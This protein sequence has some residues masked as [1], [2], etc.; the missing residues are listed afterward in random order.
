MT[1]QEKMTIIDLI[2]GA[3]KEGG[4]QS[5]TSLPNRLSAGGIP[6][7]V[8]TPLK[9]NLES[10]AEFSIF[11]IIG[12]ETIDFAST[13]LSRF[14][15]LLTDKVPYQVPVTPVSAAAV[16]EAAREAGLNRELY[17]S[18]E[19]VQ[20]LLRIYPA[21]QLM[22]APAPSIS[23][24]ELDYIH[25]IT[26]VNWKQVLNKL[27]RNSPAAAG[28]I[29]QLRG[30]LVH[31]FAAALL[32]GEGM[33]LDDMDGE[34]PRVVFTTGY[35][36]EK[37]ENLYCVLQ[38]N[39]KDSSRQAWMVAG[40]VYPNEQDESGLGAWLARSFFSQP[41]AN[42]QA[43]RT[44][45]ETL[46]A[47]RNKLLPALPAFLAS[48][49][50]GTCPQPVSEDILQYET[51]WQSL[52]NGLRQIPSLTVSE[53][54]PL[55]DI[56]ALLNE[57]D[58]LSNLSRDAVI[59]FE[60]IC[61]G[62]AKL[63]SLLQGTVP[64][65]DLQTVRGLFASQDVQADVQTFREVLRPYVC[66]K[67][68][69]CAA[70]R[71]AVTGSIT[72]IA[73]HFT[74]NKMD[75][76]E[77]LVG[78]YSVKYAFLNSLTEIENILESCLRSAA[79]EETAARQPMDADILE[80][81][82]FSGDGSLSQRWILEYQAL[83]P[84]DPQLRS[85]I[86]PATG[87]DR[88]ELTPGSVAA[89]LLAKSGNQDRLAERYLLLGL[90]TDRNA[91][92]PQLL[93]L[94]RENQDE[95]RFLRLWQSDFRDS[96][97]A[98]EDACYWLSIHC[99]EDPIRWDEVEQFST[100]YPN[101]KQSQAYKDAMLEQLSQSGQHS[102]AYLRWVGMKAPRLNA[103]ETAVAGS[104]MD[105]LY[106]LLADAAQM[107]E[108]GY[109]P[110]EIT[111]I[112]QATVGE[113][114]VGT[115]PYAKALRLYQVQDNKNGSAERLLWTAPLTP[116]VLK[117]LFDI[118]HSAGDYRSLCWMTQKFS[119][120][121]DTLARSAAYAE[122]L[123]QTKQYHALSELMS[124]HPELWHRS[125]LLA[126][127][128]DSPWQE[129]CQREN[130]RPVRQPSE[131]C[132]ALI[133][134][135]TAAMDTLL[136]QEDRMVLWGYTPE[137]IQT[138]RDK[139][140]EG[141]APAGTDRVSVVK[142]F[143]HYQGNHNRDL[144]AYLY[145]QFDAQGDWAVQHL[146]ALAFAEGRYQ[147]ASAYYDARPLLAR[148]P[149]NVSMHMWCLLHQGKTEALLQEA[150]LHPDSLR[151]DDALTQAVLDIARQENMVEFS[152]NLQRTIA[153]LPRNAF[154][155][156]VMSAKYTD[157]QKYVSD[158]DL[159]TSLGYSAESIARF[160]DRVTKPLPAGADG[161][162]LAI[163]MRL[164]FGNDRAI[165]FLL[166]SLDD[167][168]SVRLLMDIYSSAQ[169]WD[170][171]CSLYRAQLPTGIWNAFYEQRYYDALSR[172]HDR[173]NCQLY[174]YYLHS[175][176]NPDQTSAEYH[177]KYLR[178]L[179]GTNQEN[180]A[181]SQ[182]RF[183][184]EGGIE[185]IYDVAFDAFDMVW[186][187]G[188]DHLRRQTALFAARMYLK[189]MDSMPL[190]K[191]KA[192][193][194]LN[195]NLLQEEASEDWIAL[196][197][198]NGLER[199][200]TFLM[201]YFK[202]GIRDDEAGIQSA[203]DALFSM[204]SDSDEHCQ[205]SMLTAVTSFAL[206]NELLPDDA[207]ER[208]ESLLSCWLDV[209]LSREEKT[210]LLGLETVTDT[211]FSAF[212]SFW[213]T[214]TLSQAQIDRILGSCFR[215]DLE[216]N[217]HSSKFFL[218]ATTLLS[219]L[220]QNPS[221]AKQFGDQL[222]LRFSRWLATIP[223]EDAAAIKTAVHYLENAALDYDQAK[224]LLQSQADSSILY[225]PAVQ[226][227]FFTGNWPDL[228][229]SYLQSLFFQSEEE[230]QQ[231][232]ILRQ[233]QTLLQGQ[234]FEIPTDPD[235]LRFAY[236]IVCADPTTENLN[237]LLS[238]YTRAEKE[239]HA[240]IIARMA[241]ANQGNTDSLY[242]WFCQILD[243]QSVDWI[244]YYSQWWAPLF[245]LRDSD[246]QT[247]S[248]ISYLSDDTA[249]MQYR[250]SILRLLISDLNNPVYIGCYL[251]LEKEL[252]PAAIAK[253]S[254]IRATHD[255][256]ACADA[257]R[258]CIANGQYLY[259]V[260]LLTT[261]VKPVAANAVFIGQT[262]SEIYT[263]EA[264]AACPELAEYVPDVFRLIIALNQAD[265]V[266]AW[267]NIGRAVDIAILTRQETVFLDIFNQEYQNMYATYSGKCAALIAN[268]ILRREFETA[269]RYIQ[270]CSQRTSDD[271]YL[272]IALLSFVIDEC[273]QT[274]TLSDENEILVRSVPVSGNMRSLEHYGSL[275]HYAL[276]EQKIEACAKAFY[277][278]LGYV[279]QDKAL[280]ACCIQLYTVIAEQLSI[281][282]LYHAA[283]SYLA[284]VQDSLINRTGRIMA[285]IAACSEGE[286][287][288]RQLLDDCR[289]RILDAAVLTEVK[290]LYQECI[291][292]LEGALGQTEMKQFLL[293]AATG[294]WKIDGSTVT[295]FSTF[296]SICEK[297]TALHPSAFYSACIAGALRNHQDSPLSSAIIGL[298]QDYKWG[299]EQLTEA[300]K[301][302]VELQEKIIRMTDSPVELP[303]IFS[304]YLQQVLAEPDDEVFRRL[305]NI[306][307]AAQRNFTYVQYET[308]MF[309]LKEMSEL[310]PH[311]RQYEL[312]RLI[313]KK[314]VMANNIL[315]LPRQ[316]V[317]AGEY[318]MA[319]I[320]AEK[321]LEKRNTLFY[322]TL[323][324]TYLELGKF[325][326]QTSTARKYTLQQLM[327]M[328]TLLSQSNSYVD[329]HKL[330][331]VCPAKWK[332]CLRSAQEFIQGNP[333]NVLYLLN[334]AAFQTHDG[335]YKFVYTLA[336]NYLDNPDWRRSLQE[337]NS[338]LN[339]LPNWG[340]FNL[341][342]APVP[343]SP[344]SVFLIRSTSRNHANLESYKGFVD[345]CVAEMKREDA[346][347]K[348]ASA[349]AVTGQET[350]ALT[351]PDVPMDPGVDIWKLD[352]IADCL[353]RYQPENEPAPEA[354][355][356]EQNAADIANSREEKKAALLKALKLSRSDAETIEI[357]TKLLALMRQ[358]PVTF[359]TKEIC[360]RL[361][362][363][364]YCEKR[365]HT[366]LAVRVTEEARNILYSVVPCFDGFPTASIFSNSLKVYVRECLESYQNLSQF[367][368]DC[369]GNALFSLC[370]VIGRGDR[371]AAAHL[372]KHVQFAREIGTR[373]RQPMTNTERLEWLQ[374]CITSCRGSME[375]PIA[376][377]AKEALVNM[378][379]QEIRVFRNK[380]QIHL[381]VYN[382]QSVVGNECLF[383][384]VENLGSERVSKL[385]I[386]LTVDG[387][388]RSQHSLPA[389][390]GYEMV[391]FAL[392][393]DGDWSSDTLSYKISLKYLMQDGTEETATPVEGIL[394]RTEPSEKRHRFQRYDAS[395]PADS[396]NYIERTSISTTL[397]ANYLVDG[398]FRRFPNFAIYGMKRSGKS[399]VLRRIG[400]LFKEHYEDSLRYVIVSC[401]GITGDIYAR[402]HSVFV[403][404]VLDELDYKFD[405]QNRDGWQE[406]KKKWEDFPESTTD[407]R[408]IDSFY[409][410]LTRQW[411]NDTGLVIL[412]DEIERLYFEVDEYDG[413]TAEGEDAS[414]P[415]D[416]GSNNVE[417]VL[418]NVIN[419]I[420]QRDGSMIRFVL[421]GSDFFTSKIIAEG[422][423]LTQFFQKGVKLNV[424]RMEY[425]EIKAALCAN[426]SLTLHEDT[427]NYLWDIA[428]GLP[429]HSK[430]FCNSVIENQLIRREANTRTIVYP[431]DIQDAID[432]ILSTTKDIASPANFGL[433]S[434]SP[435]EELL[436]RTIADALDSR[437][438]KISLDEVLERVCLADKDES[439]RELYT[440][441]L[442]S[443]V[444]ERKLLRLDKSRNY[445]FGCELYRM[446]LRHE[447]PSRF[448]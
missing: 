323:N 202:Y 441:A 385:V 190:D 308:N 328:A 133:A 157:V 231:Q 249:S 91:C 221:A 411:L 353:A 153:L 417:S 4:P 311:A 273:I 228:Q 128:E 53:D 352:F 298:M 201:C 137:M 270:V 58:T 95:G 438:A 318:S 197:N 156:A 112:Q 399:S 73:A 381:K 374:K 152:E 20:S 107:A 176:R 299:Q 225:D 227:A 76:L 188:S 312:T 54:M 434:L 35:Q 230:T 144:E 440:K 203:A 237:I 334:N 239:D 39:V 337:E 38:P 259:A 281:H 412:I 2:S 181:L 309:A 224:T 57:E 240:G 283:R 31:R 134:D 437:L 159:L 301:Y 229:Y 389:L 338:R 344:G 226:K 360:I 104:D 93:R 43:L 16:E 177:W 418:W 241:E 26:Y 121:L 175:E 160:K 75:I 304:R 195:G 70:D 207:G 41:G 443:L 332:L 406:F 55:S 408:W 325:M 21:Y 6:K 12:H 52:H 193:L 13:N 62:T 166:D 81:A 355:T 132:L 428:A 117:L 71:A 267:K 125:E 356:D 27:S 430:I 271:P 198:E 78:G 172:S 19:A 388:F 250:E 29:D 321:Q 252:S 319:I 348:R 165:P 108:L 34:M 373:M 10:F 257:I 278:L 370:N 86:L 279:P 99:K 402:A 161:Y 178:C 114:P 436:V 171:V 184:L 185:W 210:G 105:A 422:D 123:S 345:K 167:P 396:D 72:A 140:A 276:Q 288:E 23:G 272:Y 102:N 306:L 236:S 223:M 343:T 110:A 415:Q 79:P 182:M 414:S 372:R 383:G 357:C 253:L 262:S 106:L 44:Q 147:D 183:L 186:N 255:N 248:I 316:Y 192:V 154:E 260:K 218:R 435:E 444:N 213:K 351:L 139:L 189:H 335:C 307:L 378:L 363:A 287:D 342:N 97:F 7:S 292:F 446:Y 386:T 28:S 111:R 324:N 98:V 77:Y 403:K 420:T 36:T 127:L 17:S 394:T 131:F 69:L 289:N 365:E 433:L 113:L 333:E 327:N 258:D 206:S 432:L 88:T 3:I 40:I 45:I 18:P 393:C 243:Q 265:P 96:G 404:Y 331:A 376:A 286:I 60:K 170:A 148:S 232:S 141:T 191:Q 220:Q 216:Q 145:S 409:S 222:V 9:K 314:S 142:R 391:P 275:V 212:Y 47:L 48:V 285:V 22:D 74:L 64:A 387:V 234:T 367:T 151:M 92:V 90:I 315:L 163:R 362:L 439:K 419:K 209:I 173:T 124:Q 138:L 302:P 1:L 317:D 162:A 274:G 126:G 130:S 366:G 89:R 246:L 8:Y 358:E 371:E 347:N 425:E 180:A 431:S 416:V 424:D 390:A 330:L 205:I 384:K 368:A 247:K 143:K 423:N 59:L 284:I 155:K 37:G 261:Q 83:L 15:K 320:A 68:V 254:Y 245:R 67:E 448:L 336:K 136:A 169:E 118:Y 46:E 293:R 313:L 50:A 158:P 290:N 445:Q 49:N 354:E 410:A 421:C 115:D 277:T 168:R 427:I 109:S 400:R 11:G 426:T 361:A 219:K 82:V 187:T 398:G 305:M 116:P 369:M 80:Q 179:V 329:M 379:N 42:Y 122:A 375:H 401:E 295:Y 429:W 442:R 269:N 341:M 266:G 397:E 204:L 200:S 413:Y 150:R 101:I 322:E 380:A 85:L 32:T 164:F 24:A 359:K 199:I 149:A 233:A 263:G 94:Y 300:T 350:E 5:L 87:S 56:A 135:D 280:L 251:R 208:T 215:E 129:I 377:R 405:L 392:P 339:R 382:Q 303:G 244:E 196:F 33:L 297:L 84:E 103:L 63:L 349:T 340:R 238:L 326:T 407:F 282:D 294:W 25:A 242:S 100:R 211:E 310:Y 447:L 346:K 364:L 395:N 14:Y 30:E 65:S 268:L 291:R 235:A 174:L 66:L 119:V 217:H 61:E 256:S 120:P 264:L 194:S 214:V 296:P 51:L 146:Y